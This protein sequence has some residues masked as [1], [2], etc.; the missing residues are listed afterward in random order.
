MDAG[1]CW[2]EWLWDQVG[3]RRQGAPATAWAGFSIV[4]VRVH[5]LMLLRSLR[6]KPLA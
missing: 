4:A 2:G 6:L 3:K 1:D 5:L